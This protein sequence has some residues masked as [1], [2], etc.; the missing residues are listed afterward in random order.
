MELD[1][2]LAELE[3][4]PDGIDPDSNGKYTFLIWRS[5]IY[6]NWPILLNADFEQ[7]VNDFKESRE[8]HDLLGGVYLQVGDSSSFNYE[9]GTILVRVM[10]NR[11]GST[12]THQPEH[13]DRQRRDYNMGIYLHPYQDRVVGGVDQFRVMAHVIADI[14][15]YAKKKKIPLCFPNTFPRKQLVKLSD[16]P[17]EWD[18][19]RIVYYP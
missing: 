10:R 9:P 4:C 15:K 6:D 19:S 8:K 16:R 7:V 18:H 1:D 14:A 5:G 12:Y 2:Y 17:L 13:E 3:A 11:P